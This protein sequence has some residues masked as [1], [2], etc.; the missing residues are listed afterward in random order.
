MLAH[1][2]FEA[3]SPSLLCREIK[4]AWPD[5]FFLFLNLS[6][7]S[8]IPLVWVRLKYYFIKLSMW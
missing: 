4:L 5:I 2:L 3:L 1:F 7:I 8:N 6:T